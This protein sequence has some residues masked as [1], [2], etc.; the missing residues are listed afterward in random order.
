MSESKQKLAAALKG[1]PRSNEAMLQD[2]MR[3]PC[4]PR[5]GQAFIM[6]AIRVYSMMVVENGEPPT[7]VVEMHLANPEM[8]GIPSPLDWY[9]IAKDVKERLEENLKKST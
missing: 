8:Q 3:N 2:L 9:N 4:D 6:E 1:L 5:F 7:E